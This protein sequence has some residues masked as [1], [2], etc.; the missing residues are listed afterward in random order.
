[1]D[2]SNDA[3]LMDQLFTR[4]NQLETENNELNGKL[5]KVEEEIKKKKINSI[6][7]KWKDIEE[8]KDEKEE[9]LIKS[10]NS[11]VQ[12]QLILKS[13]NHTFTFKPI[14][15]VTNTIFISGDFNNW[16]MSEMKK[17]HNKTFFY[18]TDLLI[19]YE[20]AYCFYCDGT[21]LIDFD[22]PF[23]DIKGKN[24]NNII[25]V[26]D[27]NDSCIAVYENK[28]NIPSFEL[29]KIEIAGDENEFI[30]N[31]FALCALVSGRKNQL[32]KQKKE[33]QDRILSEFSRKAKYYNDFFEKQGKAFNQAYT[34]RVIEYEGVNY[35]I[36]NLDIKMKKLNCFR[37]YDPNGIKCDYSYLYNPKVSK[38]IP[39][40]SLFDS[41]IILSEVESQQILLDYKDDHKNFI[42]IFYQLQDDYNGSNEKELI[43]YKIQPDTV[44][45]NEYHIEVNDNIIREIRHKKTNCL[46]VFETMLIGET[47]TSS[48][49]VSSSMIRVYTTLYSKDIINILH[50]HL[51]DTSK[52]ITMESEFLE[53]DEDV[54]N[55]KT[56]TIDAMGKRL[57][58][59]L[60]FKDYKL[61]KI[62]YAMSDEYIDEPPFQEIRFN[63]NSIV[64]VRKGDFKDYFG[65]I[66]QFPQG[67]LA[68]KDEETNELKKMKSFGYQKKGYCGD[69]HLDELPGFVSVGLLFLPDMSMMEK[70]ENISIPVC[71][72][73]P[74]T[75]K[76]EVEFEKKIIIEK[77]NQQNE[78]INH[79]NDTY[80][81]YL[82]YQ[83]YIDDESIFDKMSLNEIKE[84]LATVEKKENWDAYSSIEEEGINNKI[85]F[86]KK[87][88]ETITPMLYSK[89]RIK[90]LSGE[91]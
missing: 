29:N 69:R 35:L 64:K 81:K 7:E 28:V 4:I 68:R 56:F 32:N 22:M 10:L 40:N 45:I 73:I 16:S 11:K 90:V 44:N 27:E 58:Y 31:F 71:H 60:L 46:V 24:E 52:E 76:E 12:S 15:E 25:R 3:S 1:M 37:L 23:K 91:K 20:Y 6:L 84:I 87:L 85:S 59:K 72:L 74:L 14:E 55:H 65:K 49:L 18:T 19:G 30:K 66:K 43:P 50:V 86:I 61:I 42:K 89:I 67:M 77:D 2:E 33:R 21:K 41:S 57:N 80:E 39:I 26:P 70:E 83:K 47:N 63:P 54:L 79:I 51:N 36:N 82:E 88:E 62:Y 48:G 9:E 5:R 78:I 53:K 8:K 38:S 34:G 75:P 13:I 17:G